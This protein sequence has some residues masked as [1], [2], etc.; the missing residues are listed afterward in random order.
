MCDTS[1]S[2]FYHFF[3]LI[4]KRFHSRMYL[5]LCYVAPMCERDKQ[6]S[7]GERTKGEMETDRQTDRQREKEKERK[8]RERKSEKDDVRSAVYVEFRKPRAGHFP[9]ERLLPGAASRRGTAVFYSF[10]V[11]AGSVSPSA[12]RQSPRWTV[13]NA[14]GRRRSRTKGVRHKGGTAQENSVGQLTKFRSHSTARPEEGQARIVRTM[15][16]TQVG[17]LTIF[18][19]VSK[20]NIIFKAL[21]RAGRAIPYI[22][23]ISTVLYH[24]HFIVNIY[25]KLIDK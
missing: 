19:Q 2:N 17:T 12:G 23:Y 8:G 21:D 18:S 10:A 22:I 6:S 9:R 15:E 1:E 14:V 24:V 11:V 7:D 20:T 13:H 4:Q 3:F 25:I 16:T 5:R